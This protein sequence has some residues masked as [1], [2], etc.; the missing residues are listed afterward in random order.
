MIGRREGFYSPEFGPSFA[1][2]RVGDRGIVLGP[3]RDEALDV[4]QRD[5][6]FL[7]AGASALGK[8]RGC[9]N[10]EGVFGLD[11]VVAIGEYQRA[12]KIAVVRNESGVCTAAGPWARLER[13]GAEKGSRGYWSWLSREKGG[14]RTVFR[15]GL[16]DKGA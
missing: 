2:P 3:R 15:G 4:D 1:E 9:E 16:N 7:D 12:G 13:R 10:D 14:G 5:A 8:R 11:H 6:C